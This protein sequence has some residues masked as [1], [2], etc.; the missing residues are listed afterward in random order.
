M[1]TNTPTL[2]GPL[3][4]RVTLV[5]RITRPHTGPFHSQSLPGHLIHLVETGRVIQQAGGVNEEFGPSHS[6]WYNE[7]EPV[8]GRIIESPWTFITVCFDA[9]NLLPPPLD[10]RV[11]PI[12]STELELGERLLDVWQNT[13]LAPTIRHMRVHAVLLELLVHIVSEKA[14]TYRLDTPTE[15][16]WNIERQIRQDLSQP[17][18]L[19]HLSNVCR[20]SKRSINRIC[21]LATGTSPM[22]RI[23]EVRL[24]YA[25]G[26]VQHSQYSITE[27]AFRVGYNRVQEFSRDYHKRYGTTPTE[28]RQ[29]KPHYRHREI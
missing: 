24:G 14:Q 25:R 12:A 7:N 11:K 27:I 18:D 3:I 6:I 15:L 26:L 29:E 22:K 4:T 1:S 17:L 2:D 16:W 28:D 23:K 19:E 9:P 20:R 21:Y 13:S 10:Q 5:D 8:K